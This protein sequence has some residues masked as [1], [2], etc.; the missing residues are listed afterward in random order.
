MLSSN[1]GAAWAAWLSKPRQISNN[2][3]K[4]F[5]SNFIK[6]QHLQVF[7]ILRCDDWR[8]LKDIQ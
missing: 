8:K 5:S 1:F 7:G 2:L 6:S 4:S 3:G